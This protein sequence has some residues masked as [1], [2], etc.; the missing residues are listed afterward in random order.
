MQ[1]RKKIAQSLLL[2][3]YDYINIA[4]KTIL[5]QVKGRL[6]YFIPK[7]CIFK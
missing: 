5:K 6:Q 4:R 2:I 3:Q 1:L 7:L